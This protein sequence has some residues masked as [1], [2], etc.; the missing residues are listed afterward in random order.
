MKG[1][2]LAA[3]R[4]LRV[5]AERIHLSVHDCLICAVCLIVASAAILG[6]GD[7]SR[8]VLLQMKFK[9][10]RSLVYQQINK[11]TISLNNS[12]VVSQN[13]QSQGEMTQTVEA[14]DDSGYARIQEA[15]NWSWSEPDADTA[16]KVVSNTE[17]LEYTMAPNGKI[18]NLSLPND[19]EASKWKEY[20]Q[21]NLE[22]S[23]PTF[24]T[25]RVGKG[26]TWMQTVKIFM[27]SGEKLDASTTYVVSDLVEVDGRKC[28]L[29]D[30]K[31]NLV[32]PFDVMESDT[33]TRR[34]V[35][36]VDVTGQLAFDY[37]N[38]YVYSQE[39]KTKIT[40]DRSKI[41]GNEAKSYTAHI[42]GELF[43][44]LKKPAED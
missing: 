2:L 13:S 24:P 37:E 11:Q 14:V 28:A 34:G 12:P 19:G 40:A 18:S 23:Q 36:K 7:S 26:Y 31:G 42:E 1:P 32:L 25:E 33:L 30:Y 44:R 21:S 3:E 38:G 41:Q 5:A 8:K 16:I 17:K 6:C 9:P 22:Q 43:F 15:S 35:D 27:P 10:G 29:I 4:R 39:E 20:A